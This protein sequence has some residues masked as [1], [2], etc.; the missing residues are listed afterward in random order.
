[1]FQQAV[2]TYLQVPMPQSSHSITRQAVA[3][4]NY[5]QVSTS[6]GVV[7]GQGKTKF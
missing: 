3:K 4:E 1:M 6:V 2:N 5:E 7:I